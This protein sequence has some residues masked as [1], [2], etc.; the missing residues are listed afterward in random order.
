LAQ[1]RP[2]AAE[3]PDFNLVAGSQGT[4]NAVEDGDDHDVGFFPGHRRGSGNLFNQIGP[5]HPAHARCITKK[6]ITLFLWCPGRWQFQDGREPGSCPEVGGLPLARQ[7][8]ERNW[9]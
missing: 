4:D 7:G 6:S 1:P 2:E 9:E 3:S 5:G 8:C